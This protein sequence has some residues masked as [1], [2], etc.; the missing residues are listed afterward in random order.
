MSI[1][2]LN[3][4]G[5]VA[6]ILFGVRFLR[7]ALD[8]LLGPRLPVWVGRY[9]DGP[10]RAAGMGVVL[11][12]LAPSTSSQGLLAVSLV[13]E[14]TLRL[15]RALTLVTGAY[16]GAS[17]LLHVV[18]LDIAGYAPIGLLF[19]V[20]LFQGCKS[21]T[22]RGAGQLVLA[23]SFVLMGV[24][25]VGSLAPVLSASSDFGAFV[26]IVESYA[27]PAMLC[28]AL[29][30][31]LLQS[32]TATLA[33]FLALSLKGDVVISPTVI[34]EVIAGA[35]VG[36]TALAL[37]V[38]WR[39]TQARRFAVVLLVSRVLVAAVVL[40]LLGR[41][42]AY[43]EGAPGTVAQRMAVAH[44]LFN[45]GA[46]ALVM[47]VAPLFE[48][49]AMR[50][51]ADNERP[52]TIAPRPLDDRWS[53]MPS[54]ALAQTKSEIGLAVRVTGTMLTDAWTALE[55][56]DL[57]LLDEVCERDDTVDRIERHVKGFLSG[58]LT[59]E[60][61]P[62]SEQRRLM[63]LRFLGDIEGVGDVIE[64]RIAP[65]IV[66]FSRRGLSFCD[67]EW[68]ELRTAFAMAGDAID[69][70]GAVFSEERIP[71]AQEM[72]R[73]KTEV[74]DAELRQRESHYTRLQGDSRRLMETTDVYVELLGE[75]KRITHL[76]AGVAHGVIELRGS[77]ERSERTG[78][79]PG[80]APAVP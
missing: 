54:M 18:A 33:I 72:L 19:G 4:L 68:G 1:E 36:I 31:A 40:L 21:P 16:L 53:D 25:I 62:E 6:L 69:L 61:D 32:T 49:L 46:L 7:K 56:R 24:D 9:T 11:G 20:I 52:D 43:F 10:V 65:L 47:G 50:Y 39:D 75:L 41:F 55:E 60:L 35:N 64:K 71:L 80:V 59:D 45:A 2:L 23:L 13:R 77:D 44:S 63:Q 3:A 12:V 26:G 57:D 42:V 70:S 29:L 76:C 79:Q 30:A 66:K 22:Q 15:R 74:R 8:K 34:I 73:I 51:I 5:G 38:G 14:G 78:V 67:E 37:F 48:R 58:V 28:A 17:L 27:L